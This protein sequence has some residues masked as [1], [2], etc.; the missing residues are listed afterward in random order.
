MDLCRCRI[1]DLILDLPK[2]F[3]YCSWFQCALV[4]LCMVCNC[5]CHLLVVCDFVI[6]LIFIAGV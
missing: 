5:C 3:C 6:V 1:L 2:E 4:G